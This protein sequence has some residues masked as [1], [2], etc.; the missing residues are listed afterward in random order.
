MSIHELGLTSEINKTAKN[1]YLPTEAFDSPALSVF[2]VEH[3]FSIE[4]NLKMG[5]RTSKCQMC[6]FYLADI[7]KFSI[8]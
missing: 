3:V 1:I 5:R 7:V 6:D 2:E 4:T 8:S